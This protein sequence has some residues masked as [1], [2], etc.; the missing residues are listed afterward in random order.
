MT[1]I[2]PILCFVSTTFERLT[3]GST[4]LQ[5]SNSEIVQPFQLTGVEESYI[6]IDQ[7]FISLSLDALLLAPA[8][9]VMQHHLH[10]G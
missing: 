9:C 3:L 4:A 7:V 1:E 8:Q 2:E 6:S 5:K 10:L